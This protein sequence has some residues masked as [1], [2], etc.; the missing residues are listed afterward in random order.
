MR[1]ASAKVSNAPSLCHHC[2]SNK[3]YRYHHVFQLAH[4][5]DRD[6]LYQQRLVI[7]SPCLL[8]TAQWKC[9]SEHMEWQRMVQQR[10]ENHPCVRFSIGLRQLEHCGTGEWLHIFSSS[11]ADDHVARSACTTSTPAT[12]S[13]SIA[14]LQAPAGTKEPSEI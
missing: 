12:S 9:R 3:P 13:R 14:T 2:C 10:A 5:R 8:P 6:L 7:R 4:P 1:R 11:Q